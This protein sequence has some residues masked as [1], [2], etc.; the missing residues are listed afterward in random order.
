[1]K[2]GGEVAKLEKRNKVDVWDKPKK[3]IALEKRKI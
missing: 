3:D 2:G 1:M